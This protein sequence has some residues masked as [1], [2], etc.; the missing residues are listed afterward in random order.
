[1]SP[2]RLP[3][4]P[5][6]LPIELQDKTRL[7]GEMTWPEVGE[8]RPTLVVPLGS[9][10]Q[11]GPHLPLDTD[12]RIATEVAQRLAATRVDLVVAPTVAIGAS[13]EHAGFP[14]T[15][16]VGTAVLEEI[17]VE[18]ARSADHFARV[19]LVNAHGGNSAALRRAVSR[20]RAESRRVEMVRCAVSGGDAHAGRTESSLMLHLAPHLVRIERAEAGETRPWSELAERIVSGGVV[21][22]SPNGVLGD[23]AGATA[24]EGARLL[25]EM[26]RN[27]LDQLRDTASLPPP[28]IPAD[29]QG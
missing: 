29:L 25:D 11:H 26:V 3:C 4:K 12:A 2:D 17:A 21:A 10:E 5:F 27:A 1:L 20:L 14:G 28:E 16:S 8:R 19:V 24:E 7:L 9:T 18:I 6:G 23:P 22:V 15:L 13:G